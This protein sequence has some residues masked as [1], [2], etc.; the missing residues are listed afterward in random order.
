MRSLILSDRHQ[1]DGGVYYDPARITEPFDLVIV[2]G[3]AAGR[4]THSLAWLQARFAGVPIVYVA[5]N[6]DFYRSDVAG[7]GLTFEDELEAGRALA[8]RLGIHFL[9]NDRIDV[10]GV[11]I[12]GATL[13]TEL[14]SKLYH[15]QAAADG[16]AKRRM[17]D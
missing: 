2:A 13:W 9:E 1:S 3:D 4:L 11:R 10:S 15:S 7:E 17:N 12:L 5:G 16:E 14:R 8:A 6:H